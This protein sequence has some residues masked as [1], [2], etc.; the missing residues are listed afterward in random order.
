MSFIAVALPAFTLGVA[1]AQKPADV[2]ERVEK[3]LSQLTLTEKISL[4]AGDGECK[5]STMAVGRLGIPKL[6]MSDGP[7]GRTSPGC[8][9]PSAIALAA[10]WDRDL[11][12]RN[13][14]A[15]ALEARARGVHM[16]LYPG[17][18]ISRVPTCGRNF[19]YFGE[20]PF[21][22]GK[23]VAA[24]IHRIEDEGV[25]ATVKHFACNNQESMRTKVSV[26]VDERTLQ[27]IYLTPFRYAVQEGNVSAVM[28]AYNRLNDIHCSENEHLLQGILKDQWGFKGLVMSDWE[29]VHSIEG[30]GHGLDLEMPDSK[31]F[32][33]E[34]ITN[35]LEE[36]SLTMAELDDS[37]RRL[38]RLIVSKGFMDRPQK[39]EDLPLD[40]PASCTVALDVAR[41]A[42]VLLKNQNQLLPLKRSTIHSIAVFGQRAVKTPILGEGSG[43]FKAYH[44]VDFLEGIRKAAGK[45]IKINYIPAEEAPEADYQV[46]P[47]CRVS[48]DGAPGLKLS[49]NIQGEP[50]LQISP[51]TV[52]KVDFTRKNPSEP[53]LGIPANRDAVASFSGV[54]VAS[55]DSDW[56][57]I[58]SGMR[59]V[60]GD[61]DS[62]I[63]WNRSPLH[64]KKNVPLPIVFTGPVKAGGPTE[65]K[66]S[67]RHLPVP[68]PDVSAAR[69]ADVAI[70]CVG[71]YETEGWDSTFDLPSD[72]I[73]LIAAVCAANPRTIVVNQSGG[74][75]EMASWISQPSAVLQSWYIGQEG[76]TALGEILFGDVNPSGHL[77]VTF[78][79]HF[80]DY[81]AISG[82]P[83]TYPCIQ[84]PG[85]PYPKVSYSEGIFVGYRGTDKAGREPLF[86]FGY[87]LS[88]TT[89]KYSNLRIH[90][91]KDGSDPQITVQF[92]VE[93]N[94]ALAGGEVSQVYVGDTHSSVPRPIRE[95]KGFSRVMLAPGE[96]KTITVDL[97]KD[98]F[99]FYDIA[100]KGWKIEPGDFRISV[101][102]SSRDIRLEGHVTVGPDAN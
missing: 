71:R 98:S 79:R 42:V 14:S 90:T 58:K 8:V 101:G 81:P 50:S 4:V 10:T 15:F 7:K 100:Q 44:Q 76:G 61:P 9:F 22:T 86:P 23:M 59:C 91:V 19:E 21:L 45:D 83:A 47:L 73:S 75:V 46:F 6:L 67:I 74:A 87:G 1:D 72:E 17:V 5:D 96:T 69:D 97:N 78:E 84:E 93:N 49:V 20:D 89:F 26:Q 77:P 40:S 34:A 85:Q 62:Y 33:S 24:Y 63:E 39:R 95:L 92:D 80:E 53:F 3:L 41:Q 60:A 54:L 25:A 37:V 35:A 13:G 52:E 65:L 12:G 32:S 27:E 64:L 2:E 29:A 70:V 99:A 102:A 51:Q 88:Y 43:S 28:C 55:E 30:L 56:Q 31:F 48:K 16:H 82:A 18:N 36:K 11:A 66:A 57:V 68:A 94:G 38:L